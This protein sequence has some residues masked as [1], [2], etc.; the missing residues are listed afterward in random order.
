MTSERTSLSERVGSE[1]LPDIVE[2]LVAEVRDL[3]GDARV[4]CALSGGVDSAVTA[5]LVHRAIGDQLTCVFVNHGMMRKDEPAQIEEVFRKQFG[6][7]LIHLDCEDRYLGLLKDV[8]DPEQKRTIIG[9]EFWKIFFEEAEK[10]DGVK[11]LAQGTIYPDIIESGVDGADHVKSH[12]NLIPFP[13]GVQ[14]EL[15]EPL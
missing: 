10:L 14:F 3:V 7:D 4:I 2:K 13:P 9:G 1:L 6:I 12:H 5:T 11:Y 15:I 8:T